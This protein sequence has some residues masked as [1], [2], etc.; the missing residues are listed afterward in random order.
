VTFSVTNT[1]QFDQPDTNASDI[2]F[3]LIKGAV[4]GNRTLQVGRR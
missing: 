4:G 2:N 1:P 3:G